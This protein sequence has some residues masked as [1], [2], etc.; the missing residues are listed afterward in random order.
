LL[1]TLLLLRQ[2]RQ[3]GTLL[4]KTLLLLMHQSNLLLITFENTSQRDS[5]I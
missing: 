4:L 2:T 3:R 5:A 1:K